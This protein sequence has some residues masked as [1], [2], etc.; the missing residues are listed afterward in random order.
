MWHLAVFLSEAFS[1]KPVLAND[2]FVRIS[3]SW[4]NENASKR[5]CALRTTPR[6][7][8]RHAN[9]R[10]GV[11]RER[12]TVLRIQAAAIRVAAVEHSDVPAR[13]R[14][15][16]LHHYIITLLHYYC[17]Q[18]AYYVLLYAVSYMRTRVVSLKSVL[19]SQPELVWI[20]KSFSL[21]DASYLSPSPG[22]CRARDYR[23][24]SAK[25]AR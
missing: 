10:G 5:E 1:L 23:R 13:L 3:L 7:R 19:R 14:I 17:T 2:C 11:V 16:L 6:G 18:R 8:R 24:R 12:G 20:K 25:A 9:Q 4:Q 21:S 22:R 15:T